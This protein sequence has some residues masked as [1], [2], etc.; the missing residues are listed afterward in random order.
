MMFI[1]IIIFLLMILTIYLTMFNVWNDI[2]YLRFTVICWG[3]GFAIFFLLV[4][5]VLWVFPI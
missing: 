1:N 2:K 5:I 3:F 4:S